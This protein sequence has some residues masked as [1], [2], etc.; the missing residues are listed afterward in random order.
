MNKPQ[1]HLGYYT[2]RN[3]PCSEENCQ[4]NA[5]FCQAPWFGAAVHGVTTERLP[6]GE[7]RTV[8]LGTVVTPISL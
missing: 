1:G 5:G 2:M 6:N 4:W 3:K 7:V 8:G